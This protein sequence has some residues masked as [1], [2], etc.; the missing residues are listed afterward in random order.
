MADFNQ[1]LAPGDVDNGMINV[2]IEIPAGSPHKIE[3]NRE[4]AIMQLDRVD[5]KILQNLLTMGLFHRRSM[6]TEMNWTVCLLLTIRCRPAYF[7]RR[8]SWV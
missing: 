2:V 1:I 4:L 6:R 3:W 7:S 5:P 8:V